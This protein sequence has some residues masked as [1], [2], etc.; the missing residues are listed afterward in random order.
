MSMNII[1]SDIIGSF[2]I[3]FFSA[4]FFIALSYAT[5]SV[6][7]PD[8]NPPAYY[9]FALIIFPTLSAIGIVIINDLK[10]RLRGK[11]AL[12][13]QFY[14]FVLV[15][16]LNTLLDLSIL[17]GLIVLTGIAIGWEFSVFKGV[18]FAV[19]VINSYFW[20]KFWTFGKKKGG[21]L[22]E[23]SQF[24][25]VSLVGLGIN[26]GAASLLVNVIGP[27]G[28][29]SPQLWANVGAVAAIVFTTAW[30]F[31]GYKFFVFKKA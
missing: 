16:G 28:G 30:N 2:V 11:F 24:I 26:V 19:A 25:A 13:Y 20:N 8:E 29:M 9:W 17:N 22:G 1:K 6:L 14:K 12:G 7:R 5:I 4:V 10:N 23:F 18:S 27:Q 3:G 21:G 15:G 31:I